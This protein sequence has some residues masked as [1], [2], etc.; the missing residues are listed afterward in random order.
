MGRV[1][2]TLDSPSDSLNEAVVAEGFDGLKVALA[3]A[4]QRH[5]ALDGIRGTHAL[6]YRQ[7]RVD[8]RLHLRRLA[9]LPNQR[10]T[11]VRGQLQLR[12]LF[13]FKSGHGQLGEEQSCRN[14]QSNQSVGIDRGSLTATLPGRNDGAAF[15]NR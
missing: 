14:I 3:Q 7:P 6:R 8:H 9:A 2:G 11:R 4:Q 12:G 10:K 15:H 1:P 13:D 5:P